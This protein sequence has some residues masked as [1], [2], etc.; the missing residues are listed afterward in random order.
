MSCLFSPLTLKGSFI[1]FYDLD[2]V[3]LQVIYFVEWPS[4]WLCEAFSWLDTDHGPLKGISKKQ[5]ILLSSHPIRWPMILICPITGY[6]YFSQLKLCLPV[7]STMKWF[8]FLSVINK[9][10]WKKN[11]RLC[12]Y[13]VPY[14]TFS[15]F[16]YLY[17]YVQMDFYFI[18][19]VI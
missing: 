19:W 4:I 12:Q 9:F 10:L 1:D 13:P 16:T 3:K 11:R 18:Q 15:L 5:A 8:F 2:I 14:Q 7:L 17:Q 6:E